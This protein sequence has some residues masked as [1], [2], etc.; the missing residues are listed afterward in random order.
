MIN[1]KAASRQ[2][3]ALVL[4]LLSLCHLHLTAEATAVIATNSC[5]KSNHQGRLMEVSACSAVTTAAADYA[6]TSSA[7][8][9]AAEASTAVIEASLSSSTNHHHANPAV[10]LLTYIKDTMV[11]FTNGL[12]QMNSDHKRCNAIRAKQSAHA[13]SLNQKRPRGIAGIQTGGISYEEYDFLKKGLV[14]RNKL[15]AVSVVM[16]CLPNYFVYYLWSFPDMMPSPFMTKKD[17]REVSREQSHAVLSTLMEMEKGARVPPWSSKLNPFGKKSTERAME[18]LKD[19]SDVACDLFCATADNNNGA[20]LVLN[21]MKGALYSTEMPTTKRQQQKLQLNQVIP[22]QILKG[23]S[24]VISANPLNK[25]SSPFGIGPLKHI[26][27]VTLADEFLIS[28]SIDLQSI[29]SQLL[30]ETC[31]SRLIGGP[32]WS[33]EELRRGLGVWLEEVMVRPKVLSEQEGLVYFNGDLA[34]AVLMCYNA[35][36]AARDGRSDS[37]LGR[38][39]YRGEMNGVGGGGS[40]GGAAA[41]S[42]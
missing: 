9:T 30:V 35:V 28:Q 4:L 37:R 32:D 42:K 16:L 19:W 13:K 27:S 34:R 26:Q 21:R 7:E 36:E 17:A 2:V 39:M 11:N 33:E 10:Q 41:S 12:S 23:L 31:S 29:H 20:R 3:P 18:R 6:T 22:K 40:E 24:K 25:G 15:L 8:L 38:V 14:D 5:R 1:R